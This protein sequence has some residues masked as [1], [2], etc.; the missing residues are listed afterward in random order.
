MLKIARD[1]SV[2]DSA[3][4]AAKPFF[5]QLTDVR[6][7]VAEAD[8][9]VAE[10]ESAPEAAAV[11]VQAPDA[12]PEPDPVPSPAVPSGGPRRTPPKESGA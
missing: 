12:A 5:E 7:A 8:T 10:A 4:V 9:E 2:S 6:E 1:G 11:D 3:D